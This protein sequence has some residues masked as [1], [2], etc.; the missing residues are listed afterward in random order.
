MFNPMMYMNYMGGGRQQQGGMGFFQNPLV[1]ASG[2]GM[3]ANL[4]GG[5][6]DAFSGPSEA[7][8]R[9]KQMYQMGMSEMNSNRDVINP[10]AATQRAWNASMP[11]INKHAQSIGRRLNLDSG[12]AQGAITEQMYPQYMQM[13][14]QNAMTNDLEKENRR[15]MWGQSMMSNYGGGY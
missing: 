13:Y 11:M 12:Q 9:S 3:G 8:K 1:Q 10:L 4:L 14:N 6:A 2:L 5:L 7:E 15:R